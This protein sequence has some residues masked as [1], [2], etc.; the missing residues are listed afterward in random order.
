[1]TIVSTPHSF[2]EEQIFV[3]LEPIFGQSLFLK[4]EAFNF[5]GSV[6]LKAAMGMVEGAEEEGILKPGSALVESSS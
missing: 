2:R 5:A 3:D 4:S 6:K 1:M